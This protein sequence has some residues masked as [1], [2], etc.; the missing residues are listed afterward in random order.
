MV[1]KKDILEIKRLA[2][3]VTCSYTRMRGCY[4]GADKN[5]KTTIN[6]RFLN[7]P[8]ELY[9]KYLEIAKE[10]FQPKKLHDKNLIL[11]LEEAEAQDNLIKLV[12]G[13]LEDED[14]VNGLY[15]AIINEYMYEGNYLILLFHDVYDV[16]KKTLDNQALDESEDVYEYVICAICPVTLEKAGLECDD[17]Q[18]KSL[19]RKWIVGKP[20]E[21][22][23]YPA[24]ED[25]EA[26]KDKALYYCKDPKYP[27]HEI[28]E[29]VLGCK[30]AYTATE[31][32]EDLITSM[33][34]V[35]KSD[36]LVQQYL[37]GMNASFEAMITE[38]DAGLLH[39]VGPDELES[40]MKL[41]MPQEYAGPIR[42]DYKRMYE[43]VGYPDARWI[44]NQKMRDEY[45]AN[46][47][48]DK[49]KSLLTAAANELSHAGTL[50]LASEIEDYLD[51]VR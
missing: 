17:E 4:V 45:Y 5:I 32:R 7:L 46:K 29:K 12:R 27:A 11:E 25:R 1:T 10:I 14:S 20:M 6:E 39:R 8:E 2:T 49:G 28:M 37:Q 3:P 9:H 51:K 26:N 47:R 38:D 34:L 24:F 40:V 15:E 23:V 22:F 19:D 36:E 21:G 48:K 50:D 35:V 31:Y 13:K 33:R 42:K 41:Y 44:Y 16:I 30:E 18:I 43:D